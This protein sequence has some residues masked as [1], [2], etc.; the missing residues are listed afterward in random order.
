[1]RSATCRRSRSTT[2]C[3][4]A[5]VFRRRRSTCSGS[6]S[7]SACIPMS[8]D[9]P[10]MERLSTARSARVPRGTLTSRSCGKWT[11]RHRRAQ[12]DRVVRGDASVARAGQ[13]ERRV[14]GRA[15]RRGRGHDG[16]GLR[17]QGGRAASLSSPR[18]SRAPSRRWPSIGSAPPAS[19]PTPR[20]SAPPGGR[21]TR[22]WCAGGTCET[23]PRP[24]T[25]AFMVSLQAGAG[26]AGAAGAGETVR[27]RAKVAP[28]STA[29]AYDIVTAVIPGA[30]PQLPSGDRLLA[31]ISTIPVRAP[32]TTPAAAPR[33]WRWRAR[34]PS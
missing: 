20:T 28:A 1:M 31:A 30:D 21:R 23:F 33:S 11:M 9:L 2:G 12:A 22:R 19:S 8:Y 18:R 32:T 13:R 17:R 24:A 6:S 3:A 4:A 25:F 7:R 34:S 14:D 27:L 16:G 15:G 5:E 29:G 10:R 26:L